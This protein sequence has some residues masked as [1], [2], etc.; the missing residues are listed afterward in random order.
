MEKAE[1]RVSE[2]E[3]EVATLKDQVAELLARLAQDSSN[4]HRP[5]SSDPPGSKAGEKRRRKRKP[6]GRKPGGQPGHLGRTRA[7]LP[8]DKIDKVVDVQLT[9]CTCGRPLSEA[10]RVGKPMRH[11]Q[12]VHPRLTPRRPVAPIEHTRDSP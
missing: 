6:S 8:P 4:S 11:Q 1:A 5:P 12:M 9:A 2:L 3:K 7:L 10:D